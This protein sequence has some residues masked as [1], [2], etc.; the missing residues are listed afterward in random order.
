M[1]TRSRCDGQSQSPN[2]YR[3]RDAS[4]HYLR[5]VGENHVHCSLVVGKARIAPIKMV[6]LPRLELTAAVVSAHMSYMLKEELEFASDRE[7]FWTDSKVVLG[8]IS[9]EE[10]RFQNELERGAN[11]TP[12]NGRIDET[13]GTQAD[14]RHKN[15]GDKKTPQNTEL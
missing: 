11:S 1:R 7:Y 15:M 13:T 9:N 2:V 8:Y 4:K 5:F 12:T 14:S 6:A 3:G 10:K